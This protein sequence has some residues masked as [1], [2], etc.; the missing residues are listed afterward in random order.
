MGQSGFASEIETYLRARFSLILVVTREEERVV[1]TLLQLCQDTKRSCVAWDIAD[2]FQPLTA[3]K[4]SKGLGKDFLAAMDI[5]QAEKSSTVFVLKDAHEFWRNPQFKRKLKNVVQALVF[6]NSSIV[7]TMP[8]ADI[9]EE[10]KDQA[11]LTEF[12][13]PDGEALRGI[14]DLLEETPGVK[15]TLSNGGKGKLIEAARGLTANQACRAFSRAIVSG[16]GLKDGDAATITQEKRQIIR[17]SSALELHDRTETAD[18]VGGLNVLKSWLRSRE[19]AFGKAAADYGLPTPKGIALVGIPGSGKSLTARMT[20]N[21]WGVPLL[22]LDVGSLFGSLVGESESRTRQALRLAEAVAP[23]VLWVD[24]IEKAM[25]HGGLDGGTSVRVFSSIL[26]W[27]QEKTAPCFIVATANNVMAVPPELL[28]KGRFDEV[29]FLDLA[30]TEERREIFSVHIRKR[31]RKPEKFDLEQLTAG[32]DGYVGAE[33]EQAVIDA[34]YT[35]FNEKREFNTE[36]IL[37]ALKRQVPLS[38]SR[39]EEIQSLRS[40]LREG[41]FLSASDGTEV[42]VKA[43]PRSPNI[44]VS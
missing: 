38:S 22:R 16:G 25:A 30:N 44:E 27:M 26:T 11:V 42:E 36:D 9:P 17:E 20:A 43:E 1:E 3:S 19:T 8:T 37:A 31:K 4:Q 41:R 34:M 29:F 35:G 13:L 28:R 14:L 5:I 40:W 10:L 6:T 2:G 24:E 7:V 21:L 23:C 18:N 32:S 39:R 12:D 33:I 15:K